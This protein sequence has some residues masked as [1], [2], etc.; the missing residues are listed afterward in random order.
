[1]KFLVI[2]NY[3]PFYFNEGKTAFD[4]AKEK[5]NNEIIK[6]LNDHIESTKPCKKRGR[7]KKFI[8]PDDDNENDNKKKKTNN[9]TR[10]QQLNNPHLHSVYNQP[11]FF[12][13]L[14][15]QI[16]NNSE[17]IKFY[18]EN[19]RKD[20]DYKKI[21]LE[22]L[23]SLGKMNV[24]NDDNANDDDNNDGNNEEDSI[25]ENYY[26]E[27]EEEECHEEMSFDN[28]N[29]NV[30]PFANPAIAQTYITKI[31]KGYRLIQKNV[32]NPLILAFKCQS[33][34]CDYEIQCEKKDDGY[35]IMYQTVHSC[36]GYA[37]IPKSEIDLAVKKVGVQNFIKKKDY[38]QMVCNEL[39]VSPESID[40]QRIKR[41]Y[42]RVFE[43]NRLKRLKSWG[44]LES[45]INII[46]HKGGLGKINKNEKE[47]INFVGF[48]PDY[49]VKYIHSDLFFP[50]VQLDT[51]F[52]NGIS[53]GHLYIMITM[54]GDR[55]ILPIAVAWAPSEKSNYTD[56]LLEMMP[57]EIPYIKACHTDEAIALF[58]SFENVG[59]ANHL[60][61]WHMSK[62]CPSKHIF[63]ALVNSQNSH[64]YM[65]TKYEICTKYQSLTEYLNQRNRWGK[66]SRFESISPRDQNL[67]TSGVESMNAFIKN[68]DLKNKEPLNIFKVIYEF[69]F[70]QIKKICVQKT[71]FTN[72]V[73]D[74][75]SYALTVAHN[76]SVT[77]SSFNWEKYDVSKDD[78]IET[79]CTVILD[80][81]E[82]PVCNCRF[83]Q[84]C[85][86]PCVHLLA[87]AIKNKIDWCIWIHPRYYPSKYIFHFQSL[88]FPDFDQIIKTN[89]D[90]PE[91]VKSLK[92]RQKRIQTPGDTKK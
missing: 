44:M 38:Y 77:K 15:A 40:T 34:N 5:Q 88:S 73:N 29:T 23:F 39:G 43:L 81:L 33:K 66:I 1:M 83:Y 56:M 71:F 85:G 22:K 21:D 86:M 84:D 50:V 67:A 36:R 79:K 8:N 42:N 26:Q 28:L 57:N 72:S 9:E 60:C 12:I 65:Q 27:E 59:I 75:L 30:A 46:E 69:G 41:S 16:L 17:I 54:T 4:I 3:I 45:F 20:I 6:L 25:N 91:G 10:M 78:E 13:N 32:N 70:I 64:E 37:L 48:V 19:R 55:T 18:E 14:P 63:K 7:P 2:F 87:V 47:E 52:Q 74:W 61:I 49:S 31:N 24:E 51:R 53:G 92:Q 82:K 35:H 90:V 80:P 58:K 11:S 76:L 89:D 68:M 62:H